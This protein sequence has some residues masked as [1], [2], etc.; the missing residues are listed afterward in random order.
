M[1]VCWALLPPSCRPCLSSRNAGLCPGKVLRPSLRKGLCRRSA[2]HD[3]FNEQGPELD[4][5]GI[6]LQP[7]STESL[8]LN[9][10]TYF[11][12]DVV[13]AMGKDELPDGL[14]SS[15]RA[16]WPEQQGSHVL[17]SHRENEISSCLDMSFGQ[18]EVTLHGIWV[19]DQL[20]QGSGDRMQ[21]ILMIKCLES[22]S[23]ENRRERIVV[24]P[25]STGLMGETLKEMG[26]ESE[27]VDKTPRMVK[28]LLDRKV[29]SLLGRD[30]V[31]GSAEQL[32][33]ISLQGARIFTLQRRFVEKYNLLHSA[34][35]ILV[36][37]RQGQIYVHRRSPRKSM[38]ALHYDMFV[39]G[40][41]LSGEAPM[42][43]ARNEVRE[44][45]GIE[46]EDLEEVAVEGEH[47]IKFND[48]EVI[49]GR[50]MSLVELEDMM[51]KEEF[52]PGGLKA[53]QETVDRGF[54]TKNELNTGILAKE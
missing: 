42:T 25:S 32:D 9:F 11:C 49:W 51:S 8:R 45:L 37:N 53:W 19:K 36:H 40:L 26:Y 31:K 13:E 17:I 44:E 24:C 47:E 27:V 46:R 12:D 33:V 18:T 23:L 3:A 28:K 16:L 48:G 21:T 14:R 43:G 1:P 54:H 34:V 10:T 15:I 52:V 35:G 22:L 4:K 5:T 39:G 29:E 20:H 2:F 7:A 6:I 41:L 30:N 50:F 38:H